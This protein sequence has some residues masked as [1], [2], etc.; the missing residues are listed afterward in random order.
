[1]GSRSGGAAL[2]RGYTHECLRF[3]H[4]RVTLFE[5]GGTEILGMHVTLAF[6]KGHK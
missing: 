5:N 3:E 4:M 1:M 2:S 6:N